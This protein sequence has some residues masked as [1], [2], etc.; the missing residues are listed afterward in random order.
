MSVRVVCDATADL[1]P[2]LAATLEIGVVDL[3]VLQDGRGNP[4]TSRAT[5]DELAAAYRAAGPDVVAVHLSGGL[6]G[7]VDAARAAAA[8]V[9]A[10]GVRVRVLDSGSAGMGLGFPVLAAARAAA[11][12]ADLDAV[13][14]AAVVVAARCR[15]LF[16]VDTL[17]HLRR[18]GRIGPAAAALGTVLSV[19]PLLQ[20]RAGRLQL[21]EKVRTTA[22]AR[23]RLAEVAL[24]L[25]G[26]G[27]VALAVHHLG[28]TEAAHELARRLCAALPGVRELHV[29]ELGAVVGVHLGPGMVGVVVCP[30]GAGEPQAGE[31]STA[32]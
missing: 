23:A 24:A 3:H 19:K 28:A 26:D 2:G 12:G 21:L 18:G 13:A 14:A 30:E 11:A 27:P 8:A 10:E 1:P 7:T 5:P 9:D 22:R 25:A 20:V 31:L 15:T 17:E 6:S 4:T 32:G 29:V 16:C